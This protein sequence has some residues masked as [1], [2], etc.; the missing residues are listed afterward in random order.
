MTPLIRCIAYVVVIGALSSIAFSQNQ[1]RTIEKNYTVPS[2]SGNTLTIFGAPKGSM[3]I[4]GG[5][6]NEIEIAAKI[7]LEGPSSSIIDQLAAVTGFITEESMGTLVIKTAGTHNRIGDKKLWK[8]VPKNM[9]TLPFRVDYVLKVPKYLELNVNGG[10]GS[11][12]ISGIEGSIRVS[13]GKTQAKVILIG[14]I[15]TAQ[16]GEGDLDVHFPERSWRSGMLEIQ[17]AKG[18]MN[19][20]L[21]QNLSA[22]IDATALNGG[23]VVVKTEQLTPRDKRI[24]FTDSAIKARSGNGGV[25]FKLTVGSGTLSLMNPARIK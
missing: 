18:N 9:L 25:P 16:L 15:F 6:S 14:G 11:L 2:G 13:Y 23:T 21:P 3:T 22:D 4:T 1:T 17:L 8:K 10:D 5:T 7:T 24:P 12:D 20:W 19:L